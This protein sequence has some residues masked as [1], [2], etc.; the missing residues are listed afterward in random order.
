MVLTSSVNV[1]L[2]RIAEGGLGSLAITEPN[3]GSD[4]TGMRTVFTPDG[5]DVLVN[6]SKRFI[7]NGDVADCLLLFGKWSEIEE[8]RKAISV[9]ILE[10]D[11]PGF[12]VSKLESKMGLKGS[13]TAELVF[14]DCRVSRAN[15]LVG[16]GEGLRILWNR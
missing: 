6:G 8:P 16:P 9:L 13:S 15:V 1:L 14:E 4:A 2:P 5:D 10:K 7:T 12:S 3:A 11:T